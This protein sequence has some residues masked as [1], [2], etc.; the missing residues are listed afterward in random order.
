MACSEIPSAPEILLC[1]Q[2]DINNIAIENIDAYLFIINAPVE[3][4]LCHL[5]MFH[6][7][8]FKLIVIIIK[9]MTINN[10]SKTISLSGNCSRLNK[11]VLN[12]L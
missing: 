1:M 8:V 2:A 6:I 12:L 11:M 5:I 7:F 10:I 3:P 9:P 4:T